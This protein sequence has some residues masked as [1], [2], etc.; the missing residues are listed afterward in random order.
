MVEP[1]VCRMSL[2]G[3]VP[4]AQRF[5]VKRKVVSLATVAIYIEPNQNE[6]SHHHPNSGIHLHVTQCSH[7]PTIGIQ[8]VCQPSYRLPPLSARTLRASLGPRKHLRQSA[9]TRNLLPQP[10]N[11]KSC[12]EVLERGRLPRVLLV[13]DC[14]RAHET[15]P[16]R[17][18]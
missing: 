17:L 16:N 4:A 2:D 1:C 15:E 13:G 12:F 14:F 9:G 7:N 3:V 8:Y 5:D 18:A 6:R 10:Y 11:G